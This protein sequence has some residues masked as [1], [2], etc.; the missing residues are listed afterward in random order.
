M[1]NMIASNCRLQH[2]SIMGRGLYELRTQR[3]EWNWVDHDCIELSNQKTSGL[4]NSDVSRQRL[5]L[6]LK[7]LVQHSPEV[8]L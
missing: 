5:I 3:V 2:Y 8:N 4:L 1:S 6:L 7:F